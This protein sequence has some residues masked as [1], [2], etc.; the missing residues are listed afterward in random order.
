M[1]YDFKFTK[2]CDKDDGD[3][4]WMRVP[5][6]YN[7]QVIDTSFDAPAGKAPKWVIEFEVIDNIRVVDPSQQPDKPGARY[8]EYLHLS[9]KAQVRVWNLL[10]A[11]GLTP[12]EG[13][14]FDAETYHE[15]LKGKRLGANFIDHSYE[16]E[17]KT[18]DTVKTSYRPF[19][20]YT[21]AADRVTATGAAPAAKP[22]DDEDFGNVPF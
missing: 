12:A 22:Q 11:T 20:P 19:F 21:S 10:K 5:G 4:L 6:D 17:G 13:Q 15:Q 2:D 8:K 14:G 9:E 18:H 1:A 7:L 16:K 3:S